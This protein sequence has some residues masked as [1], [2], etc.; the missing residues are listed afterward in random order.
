[1]RIIIFGGD[2]FCGW[3]TSLRLSNEGHEILIIDSL[4]RRKIDSMLGIKSL[5]PIKSIETRLNTW[6]RISNNKIEYINLNIAE[7]TAV[8]KLIDIFKDFKPDTVIHFA[9]QRSAPYSMRSVSHKV[10]TVNNNINATNNILAAIVESV[11]DIHLIHIGCYDD[12]TEI[13]TDSGWKLFRDLTASDK[14]ACRS[15]S[16]RSLKFKKPYK[17]LEYPFKGKMFYLKSQ[18]LD[19]CITDNHRVFSVKRSNR[20][21]KEL[22]EETVKSIQ[23]KDKAFDIGFNWNKESP[24]N[25]NI[26][27]KTVDS[28]LWAEFMGWYLSEGCT[29]QQNNSCRIEIKQKIGVSSNVLESLLRKIADIF[30]LNLTIN[31]D[32]DTINVYRL[33]GKDFCK[34]F[35]KF[36]KA[37]DKYIPS[38]L[39]E[40]GKGV[41]LPLFISLMYGDGS[42]HNR[43]FKYSS[44]SRKLAD[45]VQEIAIKCGYSANIHEC[46]RLKNNIY[47]VNISPIQYCNNHIR[48]SNHG[49]K[50]YDGKVYC[51]DMGDKDYNILFVRRNGKP[52]WSGNSTGVYGYSVPIGTIPEG[53]LKIECENGAKTEIMYPS[54]PGSIYHMT[55]C[56]DAL[57]FFFYNKN[58]GVRITDLHQGIIWGTN[59]LEND[60]HPDL[61]NRFDWD[62]EYGTALNR[63]LMQAAIGH[64]LTIY[65]TGGQTRAFININNTVDCLNIAVNN[66]PKNGDRVKI[67]N[68]MTECHNLNVLAKKIQKLTN[69]EIRYY[70]NPRNEAAEND[71]EMDNTNFLKLGLNPITLDNGLL[72][73]IINIAIK[74]K[75]RCDTSKILSTSKWTK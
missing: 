70:D 69:A 74:Y 71:L 43:G 60:L 41:L 40:C 31:K 54:A 61:I 57:A 59:I 47:I 19:F 14:V 58:D 66:P 67:F 6:K 18:K 2:G 34:Y 23:E 9:E 32:T 37:K 26:L 29:I 39:K 55:K 4:V 72:K 24:K 42:K 52:V 30:S 45:D 27:G 16:D 35:L 62:G 21:Y 22:R 73:E 15:K 25:F 11:I 3:P 13:F 75:D 38:Y 12:K 1:M 10:Y 20:D 53:Y 28:K 63:F 17:R 46:E 8:Y 68:Q 56:Q 65:G 49:Y 33:F 48:Y 7:S 5:T 64:P 36:G 51:V 50:D 44:V